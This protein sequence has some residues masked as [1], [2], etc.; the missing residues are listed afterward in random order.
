MEINLTMAL[1]C[2]FR[3]SIKIHRN[4][5]VVNKRT[6]AFVC[7]P[8]ICHMKSGCHANEISIGAYHLNE[9]T[10]ILVQL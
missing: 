6:T 1:V 7:K 4:P 9:S 8:C 3:F 10:T 2:L 5:S